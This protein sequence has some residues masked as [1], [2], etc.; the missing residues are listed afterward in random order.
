MT[1]KNSI[2]ITKTEVLSHLNKSSNGMPSTTDVPESALKTADFPAEYPVAKEDDTPV[3][4]ATGRAFAALGD[5][6]LRLESA[7]GEFVDNAVE[8]QATKIELKMKYATSSTR[9]NA[10]KHI[11]ELAVVDNGTGIFVLNQFFIN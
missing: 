7:V 1:K 9:A 3:V 11:A 4:F 6:G 5:S 10:A 8:A 2:V